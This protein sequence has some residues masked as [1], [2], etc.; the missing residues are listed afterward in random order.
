MLLRSV[1]SQREQLSCA[2]IDGKWRQKHLVQSQHL[3]CRKLNCSIMYRL[4]QQMPVYE[5]SR[6]VE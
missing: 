5:H 3:R 1:S 4:L 6:L 2:S